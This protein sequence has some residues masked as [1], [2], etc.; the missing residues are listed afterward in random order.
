[1]KYFKYLQSLS[2]FIVAIA[3]Y[4]GVVLTETEATLLINVAITLASVAIGKATPSLKAVV[5]YGEKAE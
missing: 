5:K 3:A 2:A 1:M 4:A